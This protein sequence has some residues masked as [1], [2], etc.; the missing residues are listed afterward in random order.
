[1]EYSSS[2]DEIV[3]DL[4]AVDLNNNLSAENL[5]VFT[6]VLTKA[7]VHTNTHSHTLLCVYIHAIPYMYQCA[8][9]YSLIY[10]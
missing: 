9:I 5:S 6:A 8:Y 7:Q 1:M 3:A 2:F 4:Q 10:I